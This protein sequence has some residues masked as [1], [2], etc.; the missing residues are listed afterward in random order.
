MVKKRIA[1][2]ALASLLCAVAFGAPPAS[3]K[4]LFRTTCTW[5]SGTANWETPLYDVPGG[6]TSVT[7]RWFDINGVELYKQDV[8]QKPF[9]T[10]YTY[11]G[12]AAKSSVAS[13]Q[14]TA[15]AGTK[16]KATTA[17]ATCTGYP[18]V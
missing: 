8:L 1:A 5:F 4:P 17:L 10:Y 7:M 9:N 11:A 18:A 3:A 6:T 15:F 16:V 12:A 14:A 2:A 13:A